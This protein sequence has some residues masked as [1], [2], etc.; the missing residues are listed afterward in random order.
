MNAQHSVFWV[1]RN[2][3]FLKVYYYLLKT[4]Q[5]VDKAPG[6]RSHE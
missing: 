2:G 6:L 4:A 1:S 3:T 5:E